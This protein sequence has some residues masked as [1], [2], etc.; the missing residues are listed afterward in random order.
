MTVATSW[1]KNAE[2]ASPEYASIADYLFFTDELR[3]KEKAAATEE[4]RDICNDCPVRRECLK[5]AI[6]NPDLT[7][8]GIWGG[9]TPSEI[10]RLRRLYKRQGEAALI[11]YAL[12]E[13]SS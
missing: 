1:V 9:L 3:G 10:K 12:E 8:Y 6:Q 5:F 13:I 4:A 2:C 7:E 11:Q